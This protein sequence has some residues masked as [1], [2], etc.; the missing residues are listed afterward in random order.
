MR[1]AAYLIAATAL[2]IIA[3]ASTP[4]SSPS[5]DVCD[6]FGVTVRRYDAL[7]RP[8]IHLIFTADSMFEGAPYALD[9]MAARG[10]RASFFLT[11][12]FLRDT[13][14]NDAM[15]R[16]IIADGHYVGPHGDRHILNA[17][18]DADRT[19]LASP[20]S[21][22]A[23]MLANIRLLSRYGIAADSA[24]VVVPSF[25]WCNAAQ[26]DALRRAGLLPVGPTPGIETY[27]DYTLPDMAEYQTAD[28]MHRQL[29]QFDN[30]DPYPLD[31]AIILFHL[32]TQDARPDK[33]Y[34]RLGDIID[35]LDA[36]GYTF[37]PI[38]Q[39]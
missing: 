1:R 29:L 38:A 15:V 12:N 9:V 4:A 16:R 3:T 31:G 21:V 26:S 7:P 25:E 17:D 6:S 18:W 24:R 28:F 32:G 11:G 14:R 30:G 36:R 27:R 23:D 5:P 39:P 37:T 8:A 13:T 10:V 22:V 34:H 33:L 35:T 2:A 20:D 19:T